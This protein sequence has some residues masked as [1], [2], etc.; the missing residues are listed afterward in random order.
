[1]KRILSFILHLQLTIFIGCSQASN[2]PVKEYAYG[3][4]TPYIFYISGDGGF[5]AFS[6]DLCI[7]IQHAGYS[8]TLLNAKSYFWNKKTP[9]QA[10][11][12][13]GSYIEKQLKNR[14]NQGL[15]L[16]GYSF[17]AGII[18]FI[19]TRL[20]DSLKRNLKAVFLLS[21]SASTDFEIHWLDMI[22]RS[23]KR[24]MNVVE[25]INKMG[26]QKTVSIF[27][28]EEKDFPLN[29]IKLKNFSH[30]IISGGHHFD[31][32]IDILVKIIQK[33]SI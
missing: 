4:S 5:N 29:Q 32:H 11:T 13:I 30:F 25:E 17:G 19:A 6:T 23:K 16:A 10:A 31:G 15:I 12:D 18:P 27:G 7:G 28:S 33:C 24:D 8:I 21:P 2:L 22:G 14:K 20:P 3:S 9:E 26:Q 1:M